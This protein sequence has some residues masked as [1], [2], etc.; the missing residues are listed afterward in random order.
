MSV[1]IVTILCK[2]RLPANGPTARCGRQANSR[3]PFGHCASPR[4]CPAQ[5]YDAAHSEFVPSPFEDA[6]AIGAQSPSV[7]PLLRRRPIILAAAREQR[8]GASDVWQVPIRRFT[9]FKLPA[10]RAFE[11]EEI[12]PEP[13]HVRHRSLLRAGT[14]RALPLKPHGARSSPSGPRPTFRRGGISAIGPRGSTRYATLGVV[15][16]QRIGARQAG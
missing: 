9:E 15:A 3:S 14:P 6:S 1:R 10:R 16:A 4:N 5:V 8:P 2:T 11:R 12:E 13:V 7:G